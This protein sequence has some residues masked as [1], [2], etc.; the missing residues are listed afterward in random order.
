[1]REAQD[2]T[3]LSR[4]IYPSPPRSRPRWAAYARG[5]RFDR[6]LTYDIPVAAALAT[7]VGGAMERGLSGGETK[8]VAIATELLGAPRLLL[9]DEPLTGLDSSKV[10]VASLNTFRRVLR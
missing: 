7:K 1:M 3:G 4:M 5:T 8:R 10:G 6:S 2:S 9:L